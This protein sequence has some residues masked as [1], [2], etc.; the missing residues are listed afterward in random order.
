MKLSNLR[1]RRFFV[2]GLGRTGL[3]AVSFLREE[4]QCTVYA[5]DANPDLLEKLPKDVKQQNPLDID[6]GAIDGL[7]KSPGID[8][9]V[10]EVVAALDA[11]VDLWSDIDLLQLSAPDAKYIA[12]TGTNGKSTVTSL[13]GH[14]L[15]QAGN[16]V[17]VG[18]NIGRPALDMPVLEKGDFYVLELSSYQLL[19]MKHF[20]A[21]V[22]VLLNISPD[23]LERHG[24][25]EDYIAVKEKI[26]NNQQHGD[27][28]VISVD[29]YELQSLSMAIGMP[30]LM[31]RTSVT[32]VGADIVC[33]SDGRILDY[34]ST[35]P[36]L[37][38]NLKTVE[39][40]PGLHNWQN[41]TC[42]WASIKDFITPEQF[43]AGLESF[44]GLRH[45]L[46]KVL[47]C[48][49]VVFLNDSKATNADAANRA[50]D[51]VDNI[52][53][54]AGGQQKEEGI[55]PCLE[56]FKQVRGVY[57]I[58]EAEEA[59]AETL[60]D[61]NI[62]VHRC[63]TLDKA[64]ESAYK[65]AAAYAKSKNCKTHVLL[66]PACSSWDQFDSFE[67]RGNDFIDYCYKIAGLPTP[68]VEEE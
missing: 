42:A 23:H 37:I 3:S 63:K 27:V 31:R 48:G 7:I 28:R 59:F 39:Q 13:I 65:D 10:P 19:T 52:F 46:Q 40:L 30:V 67:H 2:L 50:L 33:A 43:V 61:S 24:T 44:K 32:G 34:D 57:L 17:E 51:S 54:I 12:I 6:W 15:K 29:N 53:W 35:P 26:F 16:T 38:A 1:G 9:N 25:M 47:Q 60:K 68:E 41:M 18:G 21:D 14:L 4:L 62:P 11:G 45:R 56:H 8:E 22:A 55:A 66:S 5:W 36:R 20:H 49:S 58:G 64:T